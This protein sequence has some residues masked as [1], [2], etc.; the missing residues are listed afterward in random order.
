M[1]WVY[2]SKNVTVYPDVPIRLPTTNDLLPQEL[3]RRVLSGAR[4]SELSRL[5]ARRVAGRDT[6]G[7]RLTPADKASS[8]ARVDVYADRATSLPLLVEVVGKGSTLPALT[9]RFVDLTLAD[10]SDEV[11]SFRPPHD[12]RLRFDSVVD[13]ASAADRFAARTPPAR[14]AGLPARQEA[15]GSVGVYGRG[16]TVLIAIPLW[17]RSAHRVRED[18][19]GQPGVREVEGGL[20]LAAPPL[21]LLLAAPEPNDSSWLLAGTVTRAALVRAAR[22]ISDERPGLRFP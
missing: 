7:L 20:L 10:P 15:L 6:L 18:L 13:I 5:P 11:L 8:I 16:P 1:R 3:A 2:E 14:L 17:S 4:P 22:Q 19:Y 12:A 9:S 21:R